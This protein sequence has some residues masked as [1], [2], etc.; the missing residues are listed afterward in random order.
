MAR[1]TPEQWQ[2]AKDLFAL[3]KSLSVISGETRIDKAT[4]SKKSKAE[5]WIKGEVQHL[6]ADVV[7]AK[8]EISNL[9]STLQQAVEDDIE[10]KTSHLKWFKKAGMMMA[11]LA[12]NAAKAEPTPQNIKTSSEA[13]AINMKVAQ[14]V[15]YY[16][17]QPVIN[18]TNAQQNIS[19]EQM[20]IDL[21]KLLPN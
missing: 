19:N 11:Q 14:A 12:V 3:G 8:V 15:P 16:P 13:L 2:K 5:G 18:N 17:N 21:A 7:R 20:L 10:E 6:V 1:A 4:I 9:S